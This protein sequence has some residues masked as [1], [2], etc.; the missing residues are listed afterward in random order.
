MYEPLIPAFDAFPDEA[1]RIGR[2]L[3]GYAQV[4]IDLLNCVAVIRKDMDSTLKAM[5]RTRGETARILIAD[6]MGR[7]A[8][9]HVKMGAEFE[10]AIGA[11]KHCVKIRN[12]YAHCIWHNDHSGRLSYLNLEELAEKNAPVN[13]L[14]KAKYYYVDIPL[15]EK[16]EE[17][18]SYT[19]SCLVW[20]NFEGRRL[21][22][23]MSSH[24]LSKPAQIQPPPPHTP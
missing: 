4:E 12:N 23:T 16:Q 2:I 15:L 20:V 5:F 8:Y 6:G 24:M 22:G 7:Q 9:H 18:F 1:M 10:T 3:A 13:D 11:V 14:R 21:A 17:F 19:S